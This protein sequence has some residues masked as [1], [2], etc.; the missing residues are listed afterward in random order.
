MRSGLDQEAI[1]MSEHFSFAIALARC[2]QKLIEEERQARF[3]Q[4]L[5]DEAADERRADE[6]RQAEY[7]RETEIRR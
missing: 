4:E 3:E 7:R 2:T 1:H 5:T 6:R